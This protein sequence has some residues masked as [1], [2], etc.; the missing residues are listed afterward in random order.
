MSFERTLGDFWGTRLG[1]RSVL[2]R[3]EGT[4]VRRGEL[5]LSQA[6][7]PSL[8]ARRA[9]DFEGL[10]SPSEKTLSSFGSLGAYPP[11]CEGFALTAT[12]L[13]TGQKG[14]SESEKDIFQ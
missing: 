13:R 11:K 10:C 9:F 12:S 6:E 2:E 5:L 4:I 3:S 8:E 7:R 1:E 14:R